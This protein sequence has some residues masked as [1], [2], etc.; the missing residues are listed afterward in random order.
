MDNWTVIRVRFDFDKVFYD[1]I[2]CGN[3]G[4]NPNI[5]TIEYEDGGIVEPGW[6]DIVKANIT[7]QEATAF[8]ETMD[9]LAN[10]IIGFVSKNA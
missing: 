5:D 1:A 10:S 3:E 4:L 8:I 2:E 6:Y 9:A 7:E